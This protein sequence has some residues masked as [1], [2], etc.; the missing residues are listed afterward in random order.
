[1]SKSWEELAKVGEFKKAIRALVSELDWVTFVELQ[2]KFEPY[3]ETTGSFEIANAARN[4]VFWQGLSEK[5]VQL[6]LELG[7]EK[8]LFYHPAGQGALVYFVDGACL[9]LPIVKRAVS[10]KTPH[11]LPVCLRTVPLK[12]KKVSQNTKKKGK[13]SLRK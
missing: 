12:V 7:R 5:L 3:F 4:I 9:K 1:M 11:W 6:L 10:Y 2:R 13:K 8:Q